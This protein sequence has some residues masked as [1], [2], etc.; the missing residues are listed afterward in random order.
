M[1]YGGCPLKLKMKLGGLKIKEE[2]K[3]EQEQGRERASLTTTQN[4]AVTTEEVIKSPKIISHVKEL[5][6]CFDNKF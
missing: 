6:G 2:F 4:L 3:E 1:V 5:R